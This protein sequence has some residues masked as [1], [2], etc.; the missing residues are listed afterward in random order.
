MRDGRF[1]RRDGAG[2]ERPVL[3][4]YNRVIA[5]ELERKG[6]ELPFDPRAE[7]DVEWSPHPDWFWIWSKHSLPYLD[8]PAVPKTTLLSDLEGVPER[9]EADFVL[10]PLFSF[11][12]GGVNVRPTAADVAAIPAAE[13]ANWCLQERI[14]YGDVLAAPAGGVKVEMR[15]MLLTARRRGRA[16]PGDQPVPAR[17]RRDARRRLQS[18]HGVDG[19]VDR[20][21]AGL[22]PAARY[23]LSS[24]DAA[25]RRPLHS[26]G[27]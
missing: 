19:L 11:A 24:N 18:R 6:I 23:T 26:A 14:A 8:H 25:Q 27:T 13:R 20:P 4:V 1:F 21:V 17:A 3:R 16:A 15:I 7:I 2:R 10:K 9:V 12:G 5:D 22:K